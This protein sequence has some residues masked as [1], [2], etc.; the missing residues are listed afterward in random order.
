M[1]MRFDRSK[2]T[3][4]RT[5]TVGLAPN[6]HTYASASHLPSASTLTEPTDTLLI[7]TSKLAPAGPTPARA[8]NWDCG[9]A[10]SAGLVIASDA[11]CALTVIL[12]RY[13]HTTLVVKSSR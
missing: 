4:S 3:R 13:R 1:V 7:S 8:T 12:E 6:G 2:V 10:P 9:L 5:C 11:G